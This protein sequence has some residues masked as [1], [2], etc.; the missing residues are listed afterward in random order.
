[1]VDHVVQVIG[2][3]ELGVEGDGRADPGACETND[4]GI[5]CGTVVAREVKR[6]FGPMGFFAF[7]E[8]AGIGEGGAEHGCE[9]DGAGVVATEDEGMAGWLGVMVVKER[10]EKGRVGRTVGIFKR[11]TWRDVRERREQEEGGVT[12]EDLMAISIERLIFY[13]GPFG[14]VDCA[15]SSE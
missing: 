1:M 10:E 11:P 9:A 6:F 5:A 14:Q 7:V 13:R 8:F 2:V 15:C 3:G 12:Y 4:V